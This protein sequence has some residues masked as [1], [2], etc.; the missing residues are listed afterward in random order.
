MTCLSGGLLAALVLAA[1]VPTP[2]QDAAKLDTVPSVRGIV[3]PRTDGPDSAGVW[4]VFL[5]TPIRVG[6]LRTNALE[7]A[8]GRRDGERYADRFVEARGRVTP[9]R[10]DRGALRTVMGA[11]RPRARRP[12][13]CSRS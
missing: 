9:G 2:G 4:I 6:P 5:P 13:S 1:A 7:Q 12:P 3:Q 8:G 11:A 10:D